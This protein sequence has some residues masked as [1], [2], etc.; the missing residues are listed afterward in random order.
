MEIGGKSIDAVDI[1]VT[2]VNGQVPGGVR[3]SVTIARGRDENASAAVGKALRNS[4][5][6]WPVK[7]APR[8]ENRLRNRQGPRFPS[9][10]VLVILR[11]VAPC[12]VL[13]CCT[14][15]YGN[16]IGLPVWLLCFCEK[17]PFY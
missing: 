5:D 6:D 3:S 17:L 2:T 7:N 10:Y 13:V 14:T 12:V 4:S 9:Y 8:S 16:Y 11:H 1:A 15:G